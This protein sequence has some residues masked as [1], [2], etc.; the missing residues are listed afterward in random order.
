MKFI[1]ILRADKI[2]QQLTFDDINKVNYSVII[3]KKAIDNELIKK[4]IYDYQ[5]YNFETIDQLINNKYIKTIRLKQNTKEIF[6][7]PK[8]LVQSI[9]NEFK[10]T[11]NPDIFYSINFTKLNENSKK[12]EAGFFYLYE[13]KKYTES[14]CKNFINNIK[15]KMIAYQKGYKKK[16][17]IK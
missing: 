5:N 8:N 2:P 6:C 1:R 3:T 15:S 11:F 17:E 13:N 10:L 12:L 4:E 16:L 7:E 14:N 9:I